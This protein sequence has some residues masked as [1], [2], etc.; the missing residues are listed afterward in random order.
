LL[1]FS[2]PELK[3]AVTMLE[4]LTKPKHSVQ[5]FPSMSP[6]VEPSE[7]AV[8]V[9]SLVSGNVQKFSESAK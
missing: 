6:P 7:F 4:K 5:G 3:I 2:L 1:L 9:A 8:I